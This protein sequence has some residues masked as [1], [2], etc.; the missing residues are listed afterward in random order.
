MNATI[1]LK[2][3]TPFNVHP[4]EIY[5]ETGKSQQI[6]ISCLNSNA[7]IYNDFLT[8]QFDNGIKLTVEL[9]CEFYKSSIDF[10]KRSLRIQET[11]I[12]LKN[13]DYLTIFNKSDE[14]VKFRWH[15]YEHLRKDREVIDKMKLNFHKIK[16][17]ELHRYN[18]LHYLQAVDA[19]SH[20]IIYNR[21][22]EDEIE[23]LEMNESF[24]KFKNRNFEIIPSDGSILP[25]NSITFTIIFSPCTSKHYETV[26]YID[27]TG[28]E[29]RIPFLLSGDCIGPI[30]SF[31]VKVLH[32]NDI[33]VGGQYFNELIAFNKCPI[34]AHI[35]YKEK[36]TMFGGR[37][38]CKPNKFK[39]SAGT[40]VPVVLAFTTKFDKKFVETV[41]FVVKESGE[42]L[43]IV[44]KYFLFFLFI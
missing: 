28:Q 38:Q 25:N 1:K 6:R 21:I 39:L 23:E 3:N 32:L 18:K 27:I 22:L 37:I 31:N 44:L 8:V 4:F 5:L 33:Y 24:L 30:V 43:Q 20:E 19:E 9:S 29:N 17:N 13:N 2:I 26:A 36:E 12:G 15:S 42:V 40:E 14:S 41:E 7:E 10:D 11:F 16:E 34:S 35:E